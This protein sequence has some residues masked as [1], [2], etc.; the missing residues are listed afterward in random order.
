LAKKRSKPK[1]RRLIAVDVG[2]TDTVVGLMLGLDI[3]GFWRLSTRRATTDELRLQLHALMQAEGEPMTGLDSVLCSVAPS[4]T[5]AWSGALQ[6]LTGHAPLEVNHHT[7][8]ALPVRYRNPG[9]IGADRLANAMAARELYGRPAIVVDMGTSTNFDCVSQGGAFMGGALAPGLASSIDV[10][11]QRAAQ[12]PRIELR[13]PPRVLGRTTEEAMQSGFVN[14]FV[15][16]VEAIVTGLSKEMKGEPQVVATGGLAN[17]IASDCPSVHHVDEGL[18][19]KGMAMIWE[20][21]Q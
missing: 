17:L 12:L 13:K 4:L 20:Q 8:K 11:A 5:D 14:G 2:N 7:A 21:N 15:G 6:A 16:L 3:A 18:T 10:L 1:R 19:V 9:A